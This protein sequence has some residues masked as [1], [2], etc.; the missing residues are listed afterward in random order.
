MVRHVNLSHGMVIDSVGG[1]LDLWETKSG[2]HVQRL[3]GSD[4]FTERAAFT[5]VGEL[6]ITSDARLWGDDG[7]AKAF[8][9]RRSCA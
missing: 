2:K 8:R 5:G 6:I 1:S 9:R 3:A 7:H 4:G